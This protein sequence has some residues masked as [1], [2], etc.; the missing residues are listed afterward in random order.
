MGTGAAVVTGAAS[1]IGRALAHALHD[2]GARIVL[3]DRDRDAL[4]VVA[5]E[6]HAPAVCMDVTRADDYERLAQAAGPVDLVCLN[7]GISIA[8]GGPV[9]ETPA[10]QWQRVM[11]VNLGGLVHGLRTFVPRLLATERRGHVLV[12]ASLAGL[13]TWPGGGAYA[14][15]KH[16]AVAVAEQAALALAGTAVSVTVLCPA[17]VRTRMSEIGDD[18]ADVAAAALG[19]VDQGRFLVLPSEWMTAVQ[20]RG[21]R[22]AAGEAPGLPIPES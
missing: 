12:T 4:E 5:G 16:A 7:A 8:H 11:D 9:W 6:L 1:G 19:A 2:R 10:A 22:L 15:S 3:A 20:E 13:L 17:L 21:H 14:A 18:P